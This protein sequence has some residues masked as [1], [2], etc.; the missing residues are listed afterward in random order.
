MRDLC[1]HRH[2]HGEWLGCRY[3]TRDQSPPPL[4]LT[5]L[6]TETGVLACVVAVVTLMLNLSGIFADYLPAR[7]QR[8][9]QAT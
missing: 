9:R 7:D 3:R 2:R 1:R 4:E 6:L 8:E 5:I